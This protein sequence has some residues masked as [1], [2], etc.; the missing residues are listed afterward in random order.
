MEPSTRHV[1]CTRRRR[2][3]CTSSQTP[4]ASTSPAGCKNGDGCVCCSDSLS[5]S[6]LQSNFSWICRGHVSANGPAIPK[7]RLLCRAGR[8]ARRR[9]ACDLCNKTR[10]TPACF[11][12][13]DPP[14]DRSGP[15]KG[16]SQVRPLLDDYTDR[17]SS[18]NCRHRWV[19]TPSLP[20][21]VAKQS[22]SDRDTSP[23]DWQ[24][25]TQ[26]RHPENGGFHGTGDAGLQ[27]KNRH[28]RV[29]GVAQHDQ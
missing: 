7:A 27:P 15:G 1:S 29:A 26:N 22:N 4:N 11:G 6:T 12:N 3:L 8:S 13:T 16:K 17:S 23:Y 28:C 2:G 9:P 24:L 21:A 10:T 19:L 25:P 20:Q 18:H 14:T 5:M